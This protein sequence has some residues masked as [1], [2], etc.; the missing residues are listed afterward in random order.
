M[1]DAEKPSLG[2]DTSLRQTRQW[3]QGGGSVAKGEDQFLEKHAPSLEYTQQEVPCHNSVSPSAPVANATIIPLTDSSDLDENIN[4]PREVTYPEGGLR[5]Y[6]VVFGSFCGMLAAFG[7]MNTIGVYQT[8]ISTHQLSSYSDSTVGWIFGLYVFLAFFC[9]IQIGPV[10]DTKGPR[11]LILSGSVCLVGAIMGM[12]ESTKYWH[13][14]LSFSLLGGLGTSLI[15][16]PAVSAIGHFFL[17]SRGSAT[18]LATTGGSIGGILFPLILPKLFMTVGYAWAMRIMGFIMLFLLIIANLLIRSRLPPKVGGSVWP[19]FRIFRGATFAWT[20]AGVF[21][22]EWG[23]F[24]PISYIS[25][26][27]LRYGI[28]STFSYQ[29][30]ALINAGSFFGRWL[31]GY[32]SDLWG[33]FNLMMITVFL[34]LLV[35]LGVWLPARGNIA[36]I[37]VFAVGFGFSSGSFISLTPVCVGQLCKTEDYGRYYATAYSLVS[38]GCLTGIPI[39]GQILAVDGGDYWGLIIFTGVCIAAGLVCFGIARLLKTGLRLRIVY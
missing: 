8:Y 6:S 36:A 28:S 2:I 9:G 13:F 30:L 10:F 26:Y 38:L 23:L 39:A 12:A 18:G 17:Q 25:S 16:T 5:A 29:L 24:I 19:D 27:A 20:T 4:H 1:T 11:W 14:L 7:L 22:I 32:V 21:F 3:G 34:C 37:C 31:P 15:F 35:T 33:R